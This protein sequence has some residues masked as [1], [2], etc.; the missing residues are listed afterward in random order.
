MM[1]M[2]LRVGYVPLETALFMAKDGNYYSP[3]TMNNSAPDYEDCFCNVMVYPGVSKLKIVNVSDDVDHY[4]WTFSND[5]EYDGVFIGN[6]SFRTCI[7][8]FP[9]DLKEETALY[10]EEDSIESEYGSDHRDL[11]FRSEGNVFL[12]GK[13]IFELVNENHD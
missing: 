11:F 5:T 13:E 3:V 10:I 2:M 4:Y 9:V 6:G 7:V 1:E 12:P 8:S